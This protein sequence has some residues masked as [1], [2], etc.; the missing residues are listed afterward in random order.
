MGIRAYL[1][2][3]GKA[4]GIKEG[5]Q[6]GK[7]EERAKSRATLA[8][9]RAQLKAEQAKAKEAERA[10]QAERARA[11]KEK[12]AIAL[13]FKKMGMPFEDIAKAFNMS[14]EQVQAL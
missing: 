6:Q 2:E 10:K 7:L 8:E 13:G 12:Q 3:Q 5:F 9:A 4:L 14:I 11:E 1:M